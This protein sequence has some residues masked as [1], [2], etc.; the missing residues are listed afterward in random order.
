V[1][2]VTYGTVGLGALG[3]ENCTQV[4]GY[5]TLLCLHCLVQSIVMPFARLE[6]Q[7]LYNP[8]PFANRKYLKEPQSCGVF[9]TQGVS[10]PR[11]PRLGRLSANK[12]QSSRRVALYFPSSYRRAAWQSI[13]PVIAL[14]AS[15]YRVTIPQGFVDLWRI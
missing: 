11:M 1:K 12:S 5:R 8:T 10:L 2:Q 4:L 13:R 15:V 9:S 6:E 3:R 14:H 7:S